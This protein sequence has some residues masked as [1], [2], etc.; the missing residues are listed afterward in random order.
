MTEEKP[1]EYKLVDEIMGAEP[2]EEVKETPVEPKQVD[3]PV[4]EKIP[5]EK[6]VVDHG[7]F[8]EERERRKELQRKLEE[9][10]KERKKLEERF[11]KVLETIAQPKEE[12][13]QDP[14]ERLGKQVNVLTEFVT[15]GQ[16]QSEADQQEFKKQQEFFNKVVASEAAFAKEKPDYY[17]AVNFLKQ[18][19]IKELRLL[20][21]NDAEIAAEINAKTIKVAERAYQQEKSPAQVGYELALS[22]GYKKTVPEQKK[23]IQDMDKSIENSRTLSPGG[24]SESGTG[25]EKMSVREIDSLSD[26]EFDRLWGDLNKRSRK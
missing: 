9:E 6:K 5:E 2:V 24:A 16:Q 18:A 7:A 21:M 20:G 14:V 22:K 26:E 4:E 17:E 19:E 8:H 15:K 23:T 10:S 13:Y 12:E 1:D 3:K 11:T 25:I